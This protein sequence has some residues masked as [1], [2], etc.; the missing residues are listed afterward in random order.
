MKKILIDCTLTG[1]RG[2]AKKCAE[3]IWE[4]EKRNMKYS[5]ISESLMAEKL[6]DFNIKPDVIL[7]V[8]F[9]ASNED[10]YAQFEKAFKKIKFDYLVKFG[11]RTAGPYWARKMNKPYIIIDGGLPD[12]YELYPSLYDKD[13]Y[14]GA[15]KYILTTNFPWNPDLPTFFKNID[16][17]YF[18]IS[19]KT[20]DYLNELSKKTF[21]EVMKDVAPYMTKFPNNY[22]MVI[23]LSITNDYVQARSRTTYGAWLKTYEYDQVVGFVRRLVMD[24]GIL[25]KKKKIVLITDSEIGKVATDLFAEYK[26]IYPVTWK[27]NWNYYIE[28]ALD[29]IS[30]IT[31]SRA[32]NYQP[33]IFALSRGNNVTSAVPANGYMNEDTAAY[34]AQGLNL[35]Y[36]LE[37]NDTEYVSKLLNFYNNNKQQKNISENQKNNVEKF[38]GTKNTID[39]IIDTISKK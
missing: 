8:D 5:V 25:A 30:D 6:S 29:K 28:I 4:L 10:I 35:T 22:D 13:T 1:G 16:V 38:L 2:P 33:F 26:N 7:N 24:L 20:K 3:F 31:I 11:A 37:F 23:N 34:Q 17:C 14:L 9:S 36:N 19:D 12:K 15:E 21:K 27:K 39:V 32:A 18:P